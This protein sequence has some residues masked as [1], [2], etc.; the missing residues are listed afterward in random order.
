[1]D[2][3]K[4]FNTNLKDILKNMGIKQNWLANKLNRTESEVSRWVNG[5]REPNNDIKEQIAEVLRLPRSA[6]YFIRKTDDKQK[7]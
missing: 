4:K 5:V 1:M 6:I 2:M 3:V 7:R